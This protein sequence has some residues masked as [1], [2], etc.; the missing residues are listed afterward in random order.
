MAGLLLPEFG[1]STIGS[2][3]TQRKQCSQ[4]KMCIY[5]HTALCLV[6]SFDRH[7]HITVVRGVANV[8]KRESVLESWF[9]ESVLD[10][11]CWAQ[12]ITISISPLAQRVSRSNTCSDGM[13][14]GA[15]L[16]DSVFQKGD[17]QPH[18][19]MAAASSPHA[20]HDGSLA[21]SQSHFSRDV[22]AFF[23]FLKSFQ[24]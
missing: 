2:K 9:W 4:V 21:R 1:T 11:R 20:P 6:R 15:Y 7:P 14:P 8:S 3:S 5:S 22:L 17:W 13:K 10:C 23:F 19:S 16:R 18:V 24:P 12:S